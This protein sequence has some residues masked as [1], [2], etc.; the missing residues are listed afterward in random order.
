MEDVFEN[1]AKKNNAGAK[2][3]DV[4]M[5]FKVMVNKHY[6]NQSDHQVQ[7]RI[8]D[9]Q[10]FKDFLGLAFGDKVPDEKTIRA[11]SEKMSDSGLS[12]K[13]FQ[14][15]VDELNEKGLIFNEEQIIDAS[16]VPAPKQH[17]TKDE[18]KD[19]KN[20]KGGDSWNDTPNKKRQKDV[21]A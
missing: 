11:F 4:V 7:Y 3:Y 17:N 2:P 19:I 5:M 8:T 14:Q 12:E 6:Y 13:L 21:D 1:K 15:F 16:F 9:C 10:S 20:G 18:N